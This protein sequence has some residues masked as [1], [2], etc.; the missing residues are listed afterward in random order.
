MIF[1]IVLKWI[2]IIFHTIGKKSYRPANRRFQR[3]YRFL[4]FTSGQDNYK[5]YMAIEIILKIVIIVI[6]NNNLKVIILEK[7]VIIEF[8]VWSY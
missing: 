1:F 2:T 3:R 6:E 7:I 8:G 5:N 4:I